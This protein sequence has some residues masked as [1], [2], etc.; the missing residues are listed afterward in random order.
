MTTLGSL[1]DRIASAISPLSDLDL[2]NYFLS[3]YSVSCASLD[4][5]AVFREQ[6]LH[7]LA[8]LKSLE[9]DTNWVLNTEAEFISDNKSNNRQR[10]N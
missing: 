6:L 7:F 10:V 9:A 1:P 2:L 3:L 4:R 8:L 5:Q